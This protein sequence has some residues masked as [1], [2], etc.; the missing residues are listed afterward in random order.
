MVTPVVEFANTSLTDS[1]TEELRKAI[2]AGEFKPKQR[3][4]ENSIAERFGVARVTARAGLDR[5]VTAGILRRGQRKSAYVPLLSSKDILDIYFSREPIEV[6]ATEWL[7]QRGV[8]P[9]KMAAAISRMKEAAVAGNHAQHTEADIQM[10]R[11]LVLAAGSRRL[12]RMH[13]FVLGETQLCISQ[14]RRQSDVDLTALTD[15]HV[16][17]A[18]GIANRDPGFAVRALCHDLHS[19]RD[20]LV[21][22]S[23][24]ANAAAELKARN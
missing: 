11:E 18:D 12:C 23:S 2:M 24:A 7:S 14:V 8:V 3:L 9:Q 19:C 21:D 20:M 4:S 15:A 5:L 22:A 13:D 6:V 10:H 17:I 16:A 1:M